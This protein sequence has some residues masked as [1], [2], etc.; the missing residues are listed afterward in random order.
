MSAR[1]VGAT[2]ATASV[3]GG[4]GD[5]CVGARRGA[6]IEEAARVDAAP[7]EHRSAPV[8]RWSAAGHRR[9]AGAVAIVLDRAE[10][11]PSIIAI[12]AAEIVGHVGGWDALVDERAA[13]DEREIPDRRRFEPR[14]E[15]RVGDHLEIAV[16]VE[17]GA[18]ART[19]PTREHVSAHF[20]R[21]RRKTHVDA[22]RAV[23]RVVEH[24]TAC[25]LV[26]VDAD[27]SGAGD[28][29]I[30]AHHTVLM[31]GRAS[32]VLADRIGARATAAERETEARPA[33][34][35]EL[36]DDEVPFDEAFARVA[37][38]ER[39]VRD[40]VAVD[41][42]VIVDEVAAHDPPTST[43]DV[44]RC[45]WVGRG[46][47]GFVEELVVLDEH[48]VGPHSRRTE[49]VRFD[50]RVEIVDTVATDDGV[51]GVADDVE[52]VLA[53]GVI[54]AHSLDVEILECPVRAG[55]HEALERVEADAR[56]ERCKGAHDDGPRGGARRVR[57]DVAGDLVGA[58]GE[59][60]HVARLRALDCGAE[61]GGGRDRDI[62]RE[63]VRDERKGRGEEDGDDGSVS[64]GRVGHAAKL[65]RAR[66]VCQ[67]RISTLAFLSLPLHRSH[68][69][70]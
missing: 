22:A 66:F 18:V 30:V 9:V 31:L 49:A 28:D 39:G 1:L 29:H 62:T 48:V 63:R 40:A 67:R 11:R 70:W 16:R 38:E 53:V 26:D 27:V 50:V 36:A 56:G 33:G 24:T 51:I 45:D 17:R 68:E 23:E 43:H 54:G 55:D 7:I 37:L 52:C 13:V 44:D 46:A 41:L 10:V 25:A 47:R 20:D 57:A 8:E 35:E 14:L 21:A 42:L 65:R 4:R 2:G 32:A 64:E 19:H 5:A 12:I 15:L 3:P 34:M 59:Q 61:L 60:D 6:C 69:E 58:I